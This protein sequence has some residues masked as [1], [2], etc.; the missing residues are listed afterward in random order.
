MLGGPAHRNLTIDDTSLRRNRGT[1][2]LFIRQK[3]A[4]PPEVRR[5][6]FELGRIV[7]V[8]IL[9]I[10]WHSEFESAGLNG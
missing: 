2:W 4:K 5:L 8:K 3:Q 7:D 6:A 1:R 10:R 9:P